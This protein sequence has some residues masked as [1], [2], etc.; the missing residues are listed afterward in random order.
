MRYAPIDTS[1]FKENRRRFAQRMAPDSL[2]VFCASDIMPT[3][4]D[5]GFPFV[6]QTD[7]FWLCGVE[8]PETF[9]VLF[10]DARE[11]KQR[12]ILFVKQTDEKIA[13]WEG[14][15]L[16]KEE[17]RQAT[18]IDQVF[19][20]NE[21]Q[22]QLRNLMI[23]AQ[24]V[25][26]NTNEHLRAADTVETPDRRLI[27]WCQQCFPLHDY[28]RAAPILHQLRAL[29]SP[30][31]IERIRRA[32][33]ITEKAFRR[34]LEFIRPGVWEF[35]IEAELVHEFLRNR[36]RRPAFEPIVAS[37]VDTCVLHYVKNDKQCRDGDLVLMDFGAE[38]ANY[39]ADVTRTVPVNGRYS[40][41]QRQL[42]DA[43]RRIQQEAISMLVPGNTLKAYHVEVGRRVETE[44]VGLG[45][46]GAKAIE[47]QNPDD[48]LYKRYFMHGTSHHLG[49]NVH[50]YGHGHAPFEAGMVFTCEPGIYIPDEGLGVRLENDILIT[51]QGPEDL[52]AA[53][54]LDPG[55]I[56]AL[57]HRTA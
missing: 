50:D 48:P 16:S 26:L 23:Q 49:L 57:M 24:T 55:E 19:W 20:E 53:L 39:A 34:V 29:K 27:R 1:L 51:A 56:E 22:T 2:A 12:E 41:R 3:S 21:F 15:K 47:T 4:A 37:G 45:L 28:R 30:L 44:L 38:Y 10:P 6:Q 35:E 33:R 40:E 43:V 5:G 52:T 14:A 7:L 42:Y 18:G 46:L 8:Q 17:A 31:E 25:Y 36:S 54:P 32:C 9:L 11:E 13:V